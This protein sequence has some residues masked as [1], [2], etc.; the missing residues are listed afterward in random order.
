MAV[1]SGSG[2]SV[3]VTRRFIT[4]VTEM[5][6]TSFKNIFWCQTHDDSVDSQNNKSI[7]YRT[8]LPNMDDFD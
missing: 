1:R 5:Y 3:F 2:K 6:D 7:Q 8:G 4:N